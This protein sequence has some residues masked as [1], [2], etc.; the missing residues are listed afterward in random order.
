MY[1]YMSR[2]DLIAPITYNR[3]S[4]K[5]KNLW[6]VEEDSCAYVKLCCRW[7]D[8]ERVYCQPAKLFRK[9]CCL[10]SISRHYN[11]SSKRPLLPELKK[12]FSSPAAVNAVLKITLTY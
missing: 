8:L 9:R 10:L 3:G 6:S 1:T 2:V 5:V 12:S 4:Y 7:R 11:I